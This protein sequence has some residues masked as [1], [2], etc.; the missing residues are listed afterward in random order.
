MAFKMKGPGLPGWRKQQGTGFYKMN[1]DT[2]K[3][4]PAL[5]GENNDDSD[6]NAEVQAAWNE[7][8]DEEKDRLNK[9]GMNWKEWS[10]WQV[11]EYKNANDELVK[12]ERRTRIGNYL[13]HKDPKEL[14][15]D[16]EWKKF[17]EEN[18][19]W[20]PPI[21]E[22]GSV[23]DVETRQIP[24]SYTNRK[25]YYR[26]LK[27]DISRSNSAD[28]T[29]MIEIFQADG[30]PFGVV[31]A[32]ELHAKYL[33]DGDLKQEHD[34]SGGRAKNLT[35]SLLMSEDF[36]NNQ[37]SPMMDIKKANEKSAAELMQNFTGSREELNWML[38]NDPRYRTDVAGLTGFNKALY[39][40][41]SVKEVSG[42]YSHPKVLAEKD[43]FNWTSSKQQKFLQENNIPLQNS[44]IG[45]GKSIMPFNPSDYTIDE[46]G[47]TVAKDGAVV[48]SHDDWINMTEADRREFMKNDDYFDAHHQLGYVDNKGNKLY[49]GQVKQT[50]Q[51][52]K[53]LYDQQ[54]GKIDFSKF[55]TDKDGN[56][57][58]D[59]R[60]V[61]TPDSITRQLGLA[62]IDSNLG[63][64]ILNDF[65]SEIYAEE[66]KHDAHTVD[67]SKLDVMD[68]S[69][70]PQ[71]KQYV[72]NFVETIHGNQ[73]F[74]K[75]WNSNTNSYDVVTK[76]I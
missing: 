17:L 45:N 4:T 8:P 15:P 3:R 48:T 42:Y 7:M 60:P 13:S 40:S 63:K 64:S 67:P 30:K 21:T 51:F 20:T 41:G 33:A 49:S 46:N 2:S 74:T 76:N 23:E 70:D 35:G 1:V 73:K 39:N 37:Y 65:S 19:G 53:N 11:H 14:M 9:M 28:G 54:T 29:K 71:K 10:N 27:Q 47:Q 57:L 69:W 52:F 5:Q 34:I 58:V 61:G 62:N 75:T 44:S 72:D 26:P 16:D 56:I 43:F 38:A 25:L 18:P 32:A 24:T 50:K 55:N 68:K 22:S 36:F 66:M 59:G 12:E 31:S 6:I